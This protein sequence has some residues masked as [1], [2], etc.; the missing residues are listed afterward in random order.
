MLGL[1]S[2]SYISGL[3]ASGIKRKEKERYQPLFR[4]TEP[5]KSDA[6]NPANN[7]IKIY[8]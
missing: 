6:L 5:L 4:T 2:G 1:S 3:R 7:S 8:F